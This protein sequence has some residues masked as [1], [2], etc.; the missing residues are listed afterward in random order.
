MEDRKSG[1]DSQTPIHLLPVRG[2]LFGMGF[3]LVTTALH[4]AGRD[5]GHTVTHFIPGADHYL[6][7]ADVLK[8][9]STACKSAADSSPKTDIFNELGAPAAR[10]SAMAE[11]LA[12]HEDASMD[13]VT[14]IRN[15]SESLSEIRSSSLRSL[16]SSSSICGKLG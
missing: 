3:E 9:G 15:H 16:F 10:P 11:T 12:H 1:S 8:L 2:G 6:D 5:K 13:P 14:A 4:Y 7:P